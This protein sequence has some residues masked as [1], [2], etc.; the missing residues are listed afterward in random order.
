MAFEV[1]ENT[2]SLFIN[3]RKKQPNH[4]DYT[5]TMNLFGEMFDIAGW[6]KESKSGKKYLSLSFKR[7]S[8]RTGGGRQAGDEEDVGF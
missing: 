2:G 5:G 4:P 6:K 7:Q 8:E 1:R 3:E